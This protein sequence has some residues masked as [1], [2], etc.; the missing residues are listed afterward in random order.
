MTITS[1]LRASIFVGIGGI[2]FGLLFH[3]FFAGNLWLAGWVFGGLLVGIP[4]DKF[5]DGRFRKLERYEAKN[6]A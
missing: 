4:L 2:P 6:A 3:H 5:Y 1:L